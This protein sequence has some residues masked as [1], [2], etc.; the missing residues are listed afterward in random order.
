M[1]AFVA[2]S[3]AENAREKLVKAGIELFRRKGYV[4][5]TVDEIC[6]D[7]GLTKGAFFHH[8]E[9]KEALAEECLHEWD[10]R[11]IAMHEQAPFQAVADP[12]D[13]LLAA[14]DFF[15][16]VF[17]NPNMVKSCLAGTTVQEVSETH[18]KLREAAQKCFASGERYF[19]NL[20][21]DASASR[22]V[23][24]D[25]SSLAKLWMATLQ[26]SLLLCKASRE[27]AVIPSNLKHIREYIRRLF[28]GV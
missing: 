11:V 5:T 17:E 14:M 13:K 9:S 16:G 10:C 7:A 28:D 8:F 18:P 4:A 6:D 26:G 3:N 2:K 27:D 15:V 21:A 23:T 24:V 19:Q 20:L 1:I 12:V 22:G 25:T